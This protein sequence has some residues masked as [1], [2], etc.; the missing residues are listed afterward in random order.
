MAE[1][2]VIL[3]KAKEKILR[4]DKVQGD[5]GLFDSWVTMGSKI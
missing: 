4:I 5:H 1:Q 2:Y 3:K